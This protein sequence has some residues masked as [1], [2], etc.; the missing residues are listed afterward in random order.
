MTMAKWN[1]ENM[2]NASINVSGRGEQYPNPPESMVLMVAAYGCFL[3]LSLVGNALVLVIIYRDRRLRT[4]V[5]LFIAN[6]A[7][8]DL[9]FPLFGVSYRISSLATG[10]RWLVDGMAGEALC[11]V[12]I[13][14][15]EI[16]NMVS[17]LS[18]V[19]IAVDRFDAVAFPMT[20]Q[21]IT[22]RARYAILSA[23]W[24]VP[25]AFFSPY[26]YA[27]RLQNGRCLFEWGD[28]ETTASVRFNYIFVNFACFIALPLLLLIVLYS[29]IIF[30]LVRQNSNLAFSTQE[31]RQ[32]AKE[33]RQVA[34]MSC[35]VVVV[36]IISYAPYNVYLFM[37]FLKALALET[38]VYRV[39]DILSLVSPAANPLIYYIFNEKYREGF[40]KIFAVRCA[41]KRRLKT[42]KRK[43]S[44]L[45]ESKAARVVNLTKFTANQ[46]V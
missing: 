25:V 16:S 26:F 39:S 13:F 14:T 10:D 22:R 28:K 32:R 21:L 37:L 17:T 6:M 35:V 1:Q 24:L 33:N 4:N 19:A 31:R 30:S 29:I 36:F 43:A 8:S 18:L 34:L 9:L 41:C 11:K 15:G 3:L 27:M 12:V 2:T 42:S 46:N 23:T 5:N 45:C 40:R 44:S 7:A 38:L 20:S